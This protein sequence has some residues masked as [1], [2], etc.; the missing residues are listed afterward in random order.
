MYFDNK[1]PPL[2]YKFQKKFRPTTNVLIAA[3]LEYTFRAGVTAV[4]GTRLFL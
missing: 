4:A 3:I 1:R 2:S